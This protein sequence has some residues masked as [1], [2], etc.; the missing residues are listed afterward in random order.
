[1]STT[2]RLIHPNEFNQLLQLY[3]HL[4]AEDP[5]LSFNEQTK[6]LWDEIMQDQYMRII[7]KTGFIKKL[8]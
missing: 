7:L 8:E 3:K 4:H 2:A 5:D 6:E 1:M